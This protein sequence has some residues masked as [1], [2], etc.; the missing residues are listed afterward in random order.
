M[1]CEL[2]NGACEQVMC[3][4]LRYTLLKKRTTRCSF[5]DY[6]VP[7]VVINMHPF[8]RL[9][10]LCVL[11]W[12]ATSTLAPIFRA[13]EPVRHPTFLPPDCLSLNWFSG[14]S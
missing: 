12:R 10:I 4:Q 13:N 2:E 3:K 5:L 11:R 7:R 14:P 6:V 8:D 9:R 1:L